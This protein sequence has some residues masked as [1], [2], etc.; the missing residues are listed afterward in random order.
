MPPLS[1]TIVRR[2]RSTD[3]ATLRS[4]LHATYEVTWL[5]QVTAAAA[6]AFRTEDRPG[7]YVAA[8]GH[9]FW[10]AE[11][12]GEVVGFVDWDGDFVNALHVRPDHAR[13]GVGRRLMEKAEAEIAEAGFPAVRLETDTFN[14]RSRAFYSARGYHE[15]DRY[16]DKEWNS[17]LTTLLLVKPLR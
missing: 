15:A 3:A 1:D 2:A 6:Q 8:R 7:E 10:V 16:P 13:R 11:L 9:Q 17:G 12:N 5:P 4:I 14:I